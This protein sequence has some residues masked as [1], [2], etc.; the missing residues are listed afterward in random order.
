MVNT[1]LLILTNPAKV[2]KLLP[3]I[4]NHVLK[5][6]Y[7]QYFP[8]KN[9]IS[10]AYSLP[11]V[12]LKGPRY[13]EIIAN[14]YTIA[15]KHFNCLDVR[16]L[17][18]HL[19]NPNVSIIHTKK[20]VELVIFDQTYNSNE[21]ITF[22]QDCLSNTS[23]GCKFITFDEKD[24]D[25][26]CNKSSTNDIEETMYKNVVLGG[27]FDRLHNGHKIF[28]S[29]AIL[30][31]TENLTVGVT[32]TNMLQKKIL[33]ELIETCP[34]RMNS[35]KDFTED[36]DPCLTYNVVPIT[37]MYGPSIEDPTLEMILVSE[38]TLKGGEMVNEKRVQKNLK[39]LAIH[40]IKLVEDVNH[41]E[42]EKTK[43]SSSNQ[44]MR[45]LGVR[46][47]E[48]NIGDK[49]IRPYIIGL[50]GGIASGK[51]SI[52]EKIEKLGAG[53]I[54]CDLI[55][56]SLY[57]PGMKCF[58][59]IVETFGPEYLT[60]DGEIDR[61]AL[62]SLVF[63]DKNEL[64]KLNKLMWPVILEEAKNQIDKLYKEGFDIVIIEAAVLIQAG[65]QHICHE[66]WTCIIPQEEAIKRLM[67]RNKLS[68][69][70]AKKR[71]LVQPSNIEQIHN[72]HVVVSTLWSHEIS[73]QQIQKAWNEIKKDLE[74][75]P[76]N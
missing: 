12:K 10:N 37:N 53:L 63:N 36:V 35:L 61:R 28:L 57:A 72:A 51:S 55:A 42:H 26:N 30:Y 58:N 15:S 27:T 6:L 69:E 13:F 39:Q 65:W 29:E 64:E 17:L 49:P 62:G 11:L 43:I 47:K 41:Q 7:I 48:P 76:K 40:V 25:N 75:Y 33:W 23:M 4:K 24:Q 32:D 18:S 67:E 73:Q 70:E 44:R 46:L 5:T 14:I 56:H 54:N 71:I 50:T 34:Q 3:A 1:G 21:A 16:V 22:M 8:E 9:I 45:L 60:S 52:A 2:G 19:K 38:E 74:K 59:L 68:T 66:I 20:P 31:C